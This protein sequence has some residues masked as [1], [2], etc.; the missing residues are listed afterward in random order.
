MV[1]VLGLGQKYGIVFVGGGWG[2]GDDCV[3]VGVVCWCVDY[4][5]GVC[6][7]IDFQGEVVFGEKGGVDDLFL[8][9]GEVG[10]EVV[11]LQ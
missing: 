7:V 10:Y 1:I 3:E 8:G 9:M 5:D 11:C 2:I 4:C 6:F